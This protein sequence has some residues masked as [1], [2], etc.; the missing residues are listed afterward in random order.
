MN[1]DS[2]VRPL[3]FALAFFLASAA[4]ALT[5]CSSDGA[6]TSATGDPPAPSPTAADAAP[7]SAEP[8]A[9]TADAV[10]LPDADARADATAD[11]A[12]DGA[13]VGTTYRLP[14]TSGTKMELTQ[15]CNGSRAATITSATTRTR[16]TS[17]TAVRFS[18]WRRAAARSRTSRLTARRGCGSS[19]CVNDAN[20]IVIDHGDGTQSTYLHL[21]GSS[22]QP[23]VACGGTSPRAAARDV[24]H[25]GLVERH[26][27]PLSR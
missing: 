13:V 1:G 15:D 3:P 14:W 10:A 26:P 17:E 24:G 8:D 6:P 19:S 18:S 22:L 5:A 20:Y 27:P 23:G 16:G 4:G 12:H 21:T 25:D 2:A 9:S 11:A 7:P